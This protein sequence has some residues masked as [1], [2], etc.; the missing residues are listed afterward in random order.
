MRGIGFR[1]LTS[2]VSLLILAGTGHADAQESRRSRLVPTQVITDQAEILPVVDRSARWMERFSGEWAV[3]F[4]ASRRLAERRG[5]E[6][7]VLLEAA[8][9]AGRQI[10]RFEGAIASWMSVGESL[11][12]DGNSW[13]WTWGDVNPDVA[14]AA[15]EDGDRVWMVRAFAP[16]EDTLILFDGPWGVLALHR[17]SAPKAFDH[18]R[19]ERDGIAQR[20]AWFEDFD[21]RR[22]ANDGSTLAESS[23]RQLAQ[24]LIEGVWH[25]N[26]DDLRAAG[27]LRDRDDL[28]SYVRMEF[29]PD[30][31][32]VWSDLWRGERRS[33]TGAWRIDGMEGKEA[34][35]QV[36]SPSRGDGQE[37]LYFESSES[38]V[39]R[40][41]GTEG[42]RFRRN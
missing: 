36:W 35:V 13:Q 2:G 38:F 16:S 17:P 19:A 14:F 29:R 34:R 41:T 37:R 3:D 40:A 10:F 6:S 1:L 33:V 27:L 39:L 15:F 31:T 7:V 9:E 8:E 28:N 26:S 18:V 21:E 24:G 32:L 22:S 30:G 5:P 23:L 11:P 4:D 20:R 42:L 12:T 25:A